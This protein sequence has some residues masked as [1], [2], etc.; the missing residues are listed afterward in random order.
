MLSDT[1]STEAG[2]SSWEPLDRVGAALH[3]ILRFPV[4]VVLGGYFRAITVRNPER[5]PSSGPVLVVANHPATLSEVFLLGTR[6]GRRFHFLA[7]SFVFQPW[8]RGVVAR[9]CGAMPVYR[10][11]DNPGLTYRNED[12]F[13]ACHA[14]FDR[15]GAIVIFPEGES[16]TDR[17]ILPLRT[18]A[19]RLSLEYDSRLGRE[20]TLVVIPV[21]V[22]FSDR[23]E[24]QSEA[25]L[26]V[27]PQIDLAPYR[28]MGAD[29]A[30]A[31]VRAL[32]ATIQES[33]EA[34]ILNVPNSAV[35]GF[36]RDVER[37]YIDDLREKRP[38]EPDLDLLRRVAD[39]I[40]HYK[41]TDP[42]RLYTAWRRTV[43]YWRKLDAL[44]LDD[45]ALRER[46]PRGMAARCMA[47]FVIGGAAG[48]IPAGAGAVVNY[49]P[50]LMTGVAARII[51]PA[52][53]Q[54]SA[55]RI[56]AGVVFFSLA[57]AAMAA[58]LS[59]WAGWSWPAV[60]L[61]LAISVPLG[62]FSLTYV[63]WLKTERER[64]RLAILVSRRR[65]LVARLRAERKALIREFDVARSEYLAV[66]A[67]TAEPTGGPRSP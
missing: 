59:R 63:R 16:R 67:A 46:I 23:T 55:G 4:R 56:I 64:L 50:F 14:R 43:A 8:I 12:T 66:A 30:Q 47:R 21:G 48:F 41:K 34:L 49:V 29:D 2:V 20:G 38:G 27:G 62:Y 42:E 40:H 44:G 61:F 25:V 45:T 37:L 39:C 19:A 60:G 57:Y 17:A 32:T 53:I 1:Q 31:A 33:L 54:V 22:Y 24:F 65:D 58:G 9:L 26:S 51:A 18:G 36:V 28:K 5:I 3:A 52:A 6:L 15:G 13:R 10:P 35:A 7:A 11:Q